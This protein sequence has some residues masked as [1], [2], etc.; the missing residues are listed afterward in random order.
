VPLRPGGTRA[1]A[2]KKAT[3]YKN[4][5]MNNAELYQSYPG[6][7]HRAGNTLAEQKNKEL[8]ATEKQGKF[9]PRVKLVC[10]PGKSCVRSDSADAKKWVAE[11]KKKAARDDKKKA[12]E[13]KKKAAEGEEKKKK[14][15]DSSDKK[16]K[17]G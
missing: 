9:K 3:R 14:D 10:P 1:S 5:L 2:S 13:K 4:E 15:G 17:G 8:F 12:E 16:K 6:F 11:N 7:H